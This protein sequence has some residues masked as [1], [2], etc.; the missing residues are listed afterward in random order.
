MDYYHLE[1]YKRLDFI[2]KL[3]I[4]ME[5]IGLTSIDR[6][7]FL[8]KRFHPGVFSPSID[9]EN[10]R[11]KYYEKVKYY[12]PLLFMEILWMEKKQFDNNIENNDIWVEYNIVRAKAYEFFQY[13]YEFDSNDYKDISDFIRNHYDVC[14]YHERTKIWNGNG[15]KISEEQKKYIKN[16]LEINEALFWKSP[17]REPSNK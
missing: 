7:H 8:V 14:S 2:Y 10:N 15:K 3:A 11:L 9:I 16:I 6:N 4:R 12:R 13:N 1:I 17:K 5:T